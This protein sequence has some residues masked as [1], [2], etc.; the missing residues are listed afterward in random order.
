MEEEK[1]FFSI[2][3]PVKF[4][5]H[6]LIE[7]IEHCLKLN[8]SFFEIVVF[9]DEYFE[10]DCDKVRVIPTGS[11][12]PAEKRDLSLKYA[13]G[14]ILA[15]LDDDA[16]PERNWL[17]NSSKYFNCNKNE[18]AAVCGPA[19]T[20]ISDNILQRLSGEI[21]SSFIASGNLVF[22]YTPINKVFEVDDFPSVNFLIRKECFE[23]VGGFGSRFW[24]GEDTKLCMELNMQGKKIIYDPKILVYHHRRDSFK[25]H[26]L[27]VL[28]YSVHRG[29]FVKKFQKNS[30]KLLYFLPTVFIFFLV[31]G[32]IISFLNIYFSYCY[33][34]ILLLYIVLLFTN[35]IIRFRENKNFFISFLLIPSIF[36]THL[37][38][39]LGFLKGLFLRELKK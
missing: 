1:I 25:K 37:F 7:N 14:D 20:P 15:F 6:Y 11:I 2:I 22:R 19:I 8:Y 36:L 26:L 30:A 34:S 29:Y 39:G 4:K 12:G 16:Y 17:N 32:F 5:N 9:P 24:P 31:I 10:Y 28:N 3:I 18:I 21:Y 27:Q 33:L 35:S 23:K 13:K 38:Y